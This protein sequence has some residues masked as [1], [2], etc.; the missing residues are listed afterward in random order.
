MTTPAMT[1]EFA[2]QSLSILGDQIQEYCHDCCD[3]LQHFQGEDHQNEADRFVKNGRRLLSQMD[4]LLEM[5]CQVDTTDLLD[6]E[7]M[8]ASVTDLKGLVEGVA[9]RR[10]G[11]LN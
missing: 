8:A 10:F 9:R 1:V 7:A 4:T 3:R 11:I 6:V 5:V 2:C